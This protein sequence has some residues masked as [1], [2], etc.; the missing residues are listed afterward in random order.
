MG[1]KGIPI[2]G[3]G[4]GSQ[5]LEE[6]GAKLEYIDLP[7]VMEVYEP[8]TLPEPDEVRHLTGAM[9]IMNWVQRSLHQYKLGETAMV[10]D[11][12]ALDAGNRELVNQILGEGEVSAKYSGD[13]LARMQESVL[14]GVWR[15]FYVDAEGQP[16]RDLIEVGDVPVLTRLVGKRNTSAAVDLRQVEPPEGVMNARPI[17][18]EIQ[19][20]VDRYRPGMAA[21]VINLTLLPLAAEDR[22]FLDQT[23]G[24]GPVSILSRGYG[25]CRI[26]STGVPYVWWVRYYN[27]TGTLILN[28]LEVVDIPLVARAAQEDFQDSSLRLQDMLEPYREMMI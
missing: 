17:L 5:P 3:I 15:T 9:E 2:V 7:H 14:A 27:S 19:D 21:H 28:T 24:N 8:P 18:T 10:A 16:L 13:F 11:I 4:P 20:Q 6:D 12:S 1:L 25:D 22:D 23:L 26:N